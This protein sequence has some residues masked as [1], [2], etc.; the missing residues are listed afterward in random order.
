MELQ[1]NVESYHYDPVRISSSEESDK[2]IREHRELIEGAKYN[3][4]LFRSLI[5]TMQKGNMVWFYDELCDVCWNNEHYYDTCNDGVKFYG[6]IFERQ[7][8]GF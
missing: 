4:D 6:G 8:Y 3:E 7:Q 5:V 2:W 1:L